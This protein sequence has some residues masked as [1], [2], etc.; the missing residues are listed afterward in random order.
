MLASLLVACN[1]NHNSHGHS[2]DVTG[3]HDDHNDHEH[4]A[5]VLSYTLF[6]DDFELFVEFPALTVGQTSS[7]AAH[8]TQLSTY[9]PISEGKLTVSIIKGNKGIRHSVDAPSSP[10]IFR[11]ALQPKDTGTYKLL[12]ELESPSGNVTFEIPK[13]QVYANAN[14]AA[15]ANEEEEGG[16]YISYLKEQAWK[17]IFATELPAKNPFGQIIRTV[18][19]IEPARGEESILMAKTSGIVLYSD[20]SLL[21]G[22]KISLGQTLLTLTSGEL[23]ENNISVRLAESKIN[24]ETAEINYNRH[25]DLIKDKLITETELLESKKEFESAK[26]VYHNLIKNF[27]SNGQL[28]KSNLN[29][30]I[31]NIYVTNGQYVEEGQAL[32]SVSQ[33][34]NL[35]LIAQVQQRYLEY[36]PSVVSANIKTLH[37]NKTYTFDELDGKVLSYG[38][39]ASG[40]SFMIP[41]N[42]QIA[43]KA[44]FAPGTLTEVFLKTVT[45]SKAITVPNTAIMEEQGIFYVF[46][47]QSGELFEKREI[48]IGST[49]GIRSEVISGITANERIVTL[50]AMQI[51]L[52]QASSALDPHAGHVH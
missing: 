45:N 21:E 49:D 23:A 44:D 28:I 18:A 42:L 15:H 22:K 43:N 20:N 1:N 35:L 2:H 32:V 26:A 13:I 7:F 30:Y 25:S 38:K 4:E 39:S 6:Q 50:G 11:P 52:A 36:L 41:V 14:E 37:N 33:N 9:K 3:G 5:A 48:K 51:K 27:S 29:G 24:Y 34:K 17:T 47:Q 46:V 40:N 8:F 12:F 31:K 19:K 10:G 16:D